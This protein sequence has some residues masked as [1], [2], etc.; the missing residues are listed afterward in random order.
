[1]NKGSISLAEKIKQNDEQVCGRLPL[2]Y[3]NAIQPFGVILSL[4]KQG[5][6][7]QVS[8][9][10]DKIF[11]V[12]IEDILD[13]YLEEICMQD[14][15]NKYQSALSENQSY[16]VLRLKSDP[17]KNYL[18]TIHQL[19][20]YS[21]LEIEPLQ[22]PIELE[23]LIIT[24]QINAIVQELLLSP[25]LTDL[26]ENAVKILQQFTGFDR[27]MLYK[28]DEDWNGTVL[29]EE[30]L[31][32]LNS[33]L[34]LRF[35]ASDIPAQAR[36]MYLNNPFRFIPDV[37]YT[38]SKLYPLLNPTINS[39]T[40][41]SSC[42]LR[43]VPAVH[44]EYLNNMGVYG[45]MSTPI[46]LDNRLWGLLS[47]H[48]GGAIDLTFTKRATCL[49]ISK[50]ISS[51]LH[52]LEKEVKL[53]FSN[54]ILKRQMEFNIG[55]A[56]K[57]PL[58]NIIESQSKEILAL[59]NADGLIVSKDGVIKKYGETI[60]SEDARKIFY[61]L[62]SIGEHDFYFTNSLKGLNKEALNFKELAC[63]ILYISIGPSP[64]DYILF[65]RREIIQTVFWGG[66]PND[67]LNFEPDGVT[68]HPRNSF[69]E[70]KEIVEFT[71]FPWTE[72]DVIAAKAIQKTVRKNIK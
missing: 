26:F 49:L 58:F 59:V 52:S 39:F 17:E 16:A 51:R 54:D 23:G 20:K 24:P 31:P 60:K 57:E 11:S 29:G 14:S 34:G 37:N 68:Y 2:N 42:N 63:G 62:N 32:S 7:V 6:I 40:D 43:S 3:T 41:L 45:S 47:C 1:M 27:V 19:E 22:A 53:S 56:S 38:S 36:A 8:D 9:N 4:D 25:T 64:S 50:V 72:L 13:K 48:H 65:T 21:I 61:W 69:F 44:I 33:Y 67:A 30:K 46:I 71:S 5:K 10:V 15:Y 35:P 55:F 66:N 12:N 18:A 28:F 70:W